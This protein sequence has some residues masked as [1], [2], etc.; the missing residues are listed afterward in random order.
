MQKITRIS[1]I[2]TCTGKNRTGHN[3]ALSVIQKKPMELFQKN[4]VLIFP[5][6]FERRR[7]VNGNDKKK[8]DQ[9]VDVQKTAGKT[10]LSFSEIGPRPIFNFLKQ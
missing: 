9:H 3:H 7:A 2:S 6:F 10:V 8:I 5:L 4:S 1:A